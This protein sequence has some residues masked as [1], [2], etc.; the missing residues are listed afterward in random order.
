MSSTSGN[1]SEP[2]ARPNS[3]RRHGEQIRSPL[4]GPAS[5]PMPRAGVSWRRLVSEPGR[6]G[7][8]THAPCQG[9]R[10]GGI[11]PVGRWHPEQP[12]DKGAG[13]FIVGS[14]GLHAGG[15]PLLPRHQW[16]TKRLQL[17]MDQAGEGDRGCGRASPYPARRAAP[18]AGHGRAGRSRWSARWPWAARPARRTARRRRRRRGR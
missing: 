12:P 11:A 9:R 6:D 17:V 2:T 16:I 10:P 15:D 8:I 7:M 5:P 13:G 1:G 4:A 14:L 3:A 18:A